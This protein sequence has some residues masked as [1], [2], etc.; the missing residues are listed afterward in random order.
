MDQKQEKPIVRTNEEKT[1]RVSLT[2][3]ELFDAGQ[4]MAD[5]VQAL[6][7]LECELQSFKE[8]IKGKVAEADGKVSRFGALVRQK[9]EYRPV[10]CDELQLLPME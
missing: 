3:D 9:Y 8:Q 5:A 2:Q 1:L 7:L 4:K 10:N 6:T